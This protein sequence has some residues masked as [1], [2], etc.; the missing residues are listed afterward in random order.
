MSVRFPSVATAALAVS[1]SAPAL[2]FAQAKPLTPA[3]VFVDAAP[4]AKLI[5][6]GLVAATIAA[7]VIGARGFTA[8]ARTSA[9]LSG[10]RLGGPLAGL[11]G[12]AYG[13]LN[14]SL[15]VANHPTVPSATVLAP[16]YAE[17]ALLF[18]LGMLAGCVAVIAHSLLE[19]RARR[20]A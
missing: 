5:M 20:P 13:L 4:F 9:F 7:V 12:S 18:G 6:L 10:L 1:L 17:A 15:G 2:A 14:M 3:L 19:G 16:G 11:L 8:G